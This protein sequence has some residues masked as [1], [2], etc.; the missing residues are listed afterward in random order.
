MLDAEPR[1]SLK[2]YLKSYSS[3]AL[4]T[5]LEH[6][7]AGSMAAYKA[8]SAAL[9]RASAMMIA[10]QLIIRAWRDVY[11][12]WIPY[13]QGERKTAVLQGSLTKC[14]VGVP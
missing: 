12:L 13:K 8:M 1:V 11:S 4:Q 6:G 14:T 2:H 9:S 5:L 10:E 7:N 3:L